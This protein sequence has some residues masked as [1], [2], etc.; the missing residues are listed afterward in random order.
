M[1]DRFIDSSE[2]KCIKWLPALIA[3]IFAMM[4]FMMQPMYSPPKMEHA[5]F[6]LGLAAVLRPQK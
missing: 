5:W 2:W 1:S 3:L 6:C 4:M